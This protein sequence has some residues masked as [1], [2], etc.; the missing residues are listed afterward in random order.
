MV[1]YTPSQQ[2]AIEAYLEGKNLFCH[3]DA[4]TGKSFVVNNIVN[5]AK[6]K[7]K[8]VLVAAPT[9]KAARNVN[10]STIHSLF[11]A[12]IGIIGPEAVFSGKR[13]KWNRNYIEMADLIIIDEVSMVRYD[14]FAG[15]LRTIKEAERKSGKRKQIIVV[16]DF[17]QLPPVLVDKEEEKYTQLY[18]KDLFA[19]QGGLLNGFFSVKLKEKVRQKDANFA[20]I[21]DRAREGD[22]SVLGELPIS[23]PSRKAI[24]LCALN[25]Q[26]DSVNN[27]MLKK[28]KDNRLY[29]G[30]K[31][32]RVTPEDMFAPMELKL[33]PGARVLMTVN[34]VD[35]RWVNGTDATVLECGDDHLLLSIAGKEMICE[36]V[37]QSITETEIIEETAPNGKKRKRSVQVEVGKYT[38]FPCKLGWA[39]SIHKSQGMTLE[40]VNI[41]PSGCFAHGQLYV[42]LSR[43]K[44]LDGLHLTTAPHPEQ[45]ICSQEVKD[46]MNRVPDYG[47]IRQTDTLKREEPSAEDDGNVYPAKDN[48]VESSEQQPVEKAERLSPANKRAGMR[49]LERRIRDFGMKL[50]KE[51][52]VEGWYSV[53]V[54]VVTKDSESRP[55]TDGADDARREARKARADA[56]MDRLMTVEDAGIRQQLALLSL[57]AQ[58]VYH[59][60]RGRAT[61]GNVAVTTDEIAGIDGI[62]ISKRSVENALQELRKAGLTSSIGPKKTPVIHLTESLVPINAAECLLYKAAHSAREISRMQSICSQCTQ[63]CPVHPLSDD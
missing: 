25:N 33:A 10:G 1:N 54:K 46:F 43:C 47:I 30:Q 55:S 37:T 53:L 22:E 19:F 13:D 60:L 50:L 17:F 40:E 63:S 12:P 34:D 5:D 45:L 42:A 32:G 27:K 20:Q 24:S 21:L 9:G 49:D 6:Q 61:N 52:G 18:G 28:L 62:T 41:D 29:I 4:G 36:Q 56:A 44:S 7:G 38:Q 11:R 51:S 57:D 15:V 16:G 35:K 31:V 8:V 58:E 26:A 14:L 48:A 2:R 3:G 23:K 39:I 59:E